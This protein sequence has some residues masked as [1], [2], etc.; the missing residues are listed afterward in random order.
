[1]RATRDGE[2]HACD[3]R[4][5]RLAPA[6]VPVL[7]PLPDD[8]VTRERVQGLADKA[9]VKLARAEGV[10]AELQA[11]LADPTYLDRSPEHVRLRSQHLCAASTRH[12]NRAD[13]LR[14]RC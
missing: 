2:C 7:L 4:L 3:H 14:A 6:C 5:T 8:A 12:S 9:R 11:R 1:M 10:V 13:V